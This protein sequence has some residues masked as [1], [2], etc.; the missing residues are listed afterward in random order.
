[1]VMNHSRANI[2]G[3]SE[4]KSATRSQ[5]ENNNNNLPFVIFI[6]IFARPQT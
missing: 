6:A 2:R 5:F 4:L 1:M 3:I